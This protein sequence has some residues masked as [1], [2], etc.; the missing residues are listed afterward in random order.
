MSKKLPRIRVTPRLHLPF[1]GVIGDTSKDCL[2]IEYEYH[3][4]FAPVGGSISLGTS[5]LTH[6][7]CM[8]GGE[9]KWSW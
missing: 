7:G 2:D 6:L 4:Q 8:A 5:D 1:Q 3:S 9:Q